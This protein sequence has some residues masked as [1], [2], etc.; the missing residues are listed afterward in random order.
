MRS[1]RPQPAHPRSRGENADSDPGHYSPPGS[2]P[3]TRG[4]RGRLEVWDDLEGLIPAHA[5][6]T[7]GQRRRLRG[8]AA[9]PRSRGENLNPAYSDAKINGSSP[10]T[11]GKPCLFGRQGPLSR[12]IPAHAGKTLLHRLGLGA[13]PAHPRSRGENAT[14]VRHAVSRGENISRSNEDTSLIG[15][16]PLTR[17][18]HV[19]LIKLTPDRGLIPAHAG[20]TGDTGAR[21]DDPW[22]HPR[23]RGENTGSWDPQR[24]TRGSSPLTRGKP[25]TRCCRSHRS[26]LIPAHAGKTKTR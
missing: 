7:V 26:W 21:G 2:S 14:R 5:G 17:G 16:S 3:L 18:K 24:L 8:R 20:K 22:A 12:L 11:R 13:L 23:S 6:K 4:K 1:I 25:L 10:L 19:T 15:S 9:H